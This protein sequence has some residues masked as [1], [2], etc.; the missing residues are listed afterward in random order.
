M[1][2]ENEIIESNNENKINNKDNKTN[3]DENIQNSDEDITLIER[4]DY[5]SYKFMKLKSDIK[6]YSNRNKYSKMYSKKKEIKSYY[7]KNIKIK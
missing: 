3:I 4:K 6:A 2:N 5:D 1:N 7:Q